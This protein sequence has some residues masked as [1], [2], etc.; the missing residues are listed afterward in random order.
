MQV[1]FV[2]FAEDYLAGSFKLFFLPE[3]TISPEKDLLMFCLESKGLIASFLVTEW[4]A[5]AG[6]L[7]TQG[8]HI[9]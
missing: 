3:L 4:E 5:R 6:S 9:T 7:S 8:T 2:S 1:E